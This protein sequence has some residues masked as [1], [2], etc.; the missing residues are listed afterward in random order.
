V[1]SREA[2]P[3]TFQNTLRMAG[4]GLL[5]RIL[6]VVK[7][8]VPDCVLFPQWIWFLWLLITLH[9]PP[10]CMKQ[11]VRHSLDC[12]RIVSTNPF[13][14]YISN[15]G[16]V[17]LRTTSDDQLF[18]YCGGCLGNGDILL[19]YIG[20][21]YA[22]VK[23][24]HNELYVY[25]MTFTYVYDKCSTL[26]TL[27]NNCMVSSSNFFVIGAFELYIIQCILRV[28]A[29]ILINIQWLCC[30]WIHVKSNWLGIY[31]Q[32]LWLHVCLW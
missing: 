5:L 17:L 7:L 25:C 11:C 24:S 3:P 29:H 4:E 19:C 2:G 23:R 27:I 9:A 21:A 30:S 15:L 8:H 10:K 32:F 6:L 28:K 1:S 26:M 18:Y 31:V 13:L 22:I 16:S 20:C 12:F 14:Y